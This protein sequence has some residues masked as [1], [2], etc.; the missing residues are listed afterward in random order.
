MIF[1]E[2]PRRKLKLINFG[3][4]LVDGYNKKL[5]VDLTKQGKIPGEW[6]WAPPTLER[7]VSSVGSGDSF[8][9]GLLVGL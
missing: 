1:K 7:R 8:M 2:R 4:R 5:F 3:F 6:L 9:A